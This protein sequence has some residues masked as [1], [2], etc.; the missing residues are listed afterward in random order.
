MALR[1]RSSLNTIIERVSPFLPLTYTNIMAR[2]LK[3]CQSVLDVG[4]GR[5]ELMR[6]LKKRVNVHSVGLELYL[7]YIY[8]AKKMRSHDD[9]V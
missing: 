2:S 9:F 6:N 8:E 4:C 1:R 3:G 7:P 5:G